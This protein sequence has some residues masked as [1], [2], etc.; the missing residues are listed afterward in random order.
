MKN[1]K[2]ELLLTALLTSPTVREAAQSVGVPETT[3]YNWLRKP[4]FS[5]EYEQRKRQ[6]VKEAG[7]FMQSK[8]G[9]A[10]MVL[11]E[12]MTD[13][14]APPPS[15]VSASKAIIDSAYK[16]IEQAQI[17]ERLEVLEANLGEN[18]Q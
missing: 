10:V 2:R 16:H 8:L 14:E 5:A 1:A 13:K 18:K 15:R 6:A 17:L 12:I 9:A 4:D 3:A 7:D 11:D